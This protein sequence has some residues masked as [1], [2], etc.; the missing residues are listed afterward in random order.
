MVIDEFDEILNTIYIAKKLHDMGK[1]EA[2]K[3][4]LFD[5][6]EYD[7]YYENMY[8]LI[9]NIFAYHDRQYSERHG[10]EVHVLSD[11]VIV[12]FYTLAGDYGK[13]HKIPDE[14]N[15]Y[16]KEAE[17]EAGRQLNFSYSVDW[18]LMAHTEPKRSYHS[19]IGVFLNTDDWIDIGCLAYGLIEMYEWFSDACS[20][21]RDTLHKDGI[22]T[23]QF[24]GEEVAA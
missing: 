22:I 7:V 21:L 17:E 8:G 4:S 3:E 15:P 14:N 20:R 12:D 5:V 2:V 13:I 24:P 23:L 9:E 16:I 11:P 6:L 18:K 10:I 1:Y 19:R